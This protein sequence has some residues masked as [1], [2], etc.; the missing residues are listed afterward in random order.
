MSG[1]AQ[2]D[3]F[4]FAAEEDKSDFWDQKEAVALCR[5]VEG[6]AP[7]FK[8]HVALTGGSL[9]KDGLR[10][11]ADIL[12]YRVRQVEALDKEGLLDA[13]A[14][15]GFEHYR[16]FGWV[17]KAKYLGKDV[18]LFFPEYVGGPDSEGGYA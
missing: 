1:A 16:R 5:L 15:N 7:Q 2:L 18:D 14:A 12:F 6:I 13:L 4:L 17:I 11:D 3:P 9:Y 10:K 8:C